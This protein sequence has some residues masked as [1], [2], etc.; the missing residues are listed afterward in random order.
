MVR[1]ARFHSNPRRGFSPHSSRSGIKTGAFR[2][3][4]DGREPSIG[5]DDLHATPLGLW[6]A[7]GGTR[8]GQ[9]RQVP[10][11]AVGHHGTH[12]E[13]LAPI[14][15]KPSNGEGVSLSPA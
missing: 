15:T 7:A 3:G 6:R 4:L 12:R 5:N 8:R 14:T 11:P 9:H 2:V 13:I 10:R 1:A